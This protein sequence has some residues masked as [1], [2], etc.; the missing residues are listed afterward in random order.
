MV[1]IYKNKNIIIKNMKNKNIR[2]NKKVIVKI[3]KNK[4]CHLCA[5][6]YSNSKKN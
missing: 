5:P 2:A 1:E 4:G 3:V 6:S